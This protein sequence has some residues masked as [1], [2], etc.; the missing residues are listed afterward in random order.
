[1]GGRAFQRRGN[2]LKYEYL[3][4]LFGTVT[5][6]SFPCTADVVDPV[7]NDKYL[8][9]SKLL[10]GTFRDMIVNIISVSSK[11]LLNK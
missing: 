6:L 10:L 3:A 4:L 5:Y 8:L 7:A 1:M 9:T 11:V 2:L